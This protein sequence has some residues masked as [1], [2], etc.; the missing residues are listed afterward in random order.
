MDATRMQ[1]D[2]YT[3]NTFWYPDQIIIT[4]QLKPGQI[5]PY[6]PVLPENARNR[7]EMSDERAPLNFFFPV[8]PT[9]RK[10]DA[11]DALNVESL[12][13]FL[14][15]NHYPRLSPINI[16]DT[17][18]FPGATPPANADQVGKYL[19][20]SIDI[21]ERYV[22]TVIGFF[23]FSPDEV[24]VSNDSSLSNVDPVVRLVNFIN[25]HL[26]EIKDE[27]ENTYR[28]PIISAAPTWLVGASDSR[29]VGCPLTP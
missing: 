10:K 20:T 3:H 2:P 8:L 16:R 22:P 6:S 9:Y 29:P 18:R 25:D 4:F 27:P 26:N 21:H 24:P 5:E 14:A 13:A 17:L 19:F 11:I 1:M 12:N 23:T 28:V 7:E 15:E